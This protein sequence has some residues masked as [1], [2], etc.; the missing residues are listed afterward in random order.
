MDDDV[1]ILCAN[2]CFLLTSLDGA[3]TDTRPLEDLTSSQ[4]EADTLIILHSIYADRTGTE[5]ADIIIHSPDTDVFLLL[6]AFCHKCTHQLYF[7]TGVGNKRRMI[8]IQTL[9]QKIDKDIQDCILGLHAF[10]GCD[11]NSAFVQK[12]K[13]KPLNLLLKNPNFILA[14]KEMGRSETVSEDLLCQLE[15]FV[16]HLYGK[17]SYSSTN[18]LRHDLVRQKYM[19]KGQCLLSS[20]EGLDIS[21]L[22]PCRAALHMHCLR[23]NYQA[24]IW[25]KADIAQPNIPGPQGHGWK[26][27]DNGMLSIDWC[28][29]LFPQQLA[30]ILSESQTDQEQDSDDDVLSDTN[31]SVHDQDSS[32]SETSEDEESD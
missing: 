7:D 13:A 6:I 4:E 11:V 25:K 5:D 1:C 10:T 14:F 18:K 30:D 16:C 24:M 3:T 19:V 22:P 17:P 15:K 2:Q 12:G 26:K 21:L 23:A 27:E 8:H 31:N 28:K 29:D 32:D 20:F 9:C